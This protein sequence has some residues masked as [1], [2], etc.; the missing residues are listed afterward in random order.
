MDAHRPPLSRPSPIPCILKDTIP[1][2]SLMDTFY[3]GKGI[4]GEEP[5]L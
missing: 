3:E 2:P 1:F 4:I 5:I